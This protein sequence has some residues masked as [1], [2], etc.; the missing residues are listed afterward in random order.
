MSKVFRIPI[1][2]TTHGTAWVEAESV[3]DARR[4]FDAGEFLEIDEVDADTDYEV[5]G[6]PEL[7]EVFS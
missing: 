2:W 6:E 7:D 1:K 5:V 3:K 4:Q